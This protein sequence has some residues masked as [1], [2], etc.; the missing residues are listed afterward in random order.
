[1][2]GDREDPLQTLSLYFPISPRLALY[3]GEPGEVTDTPFEAMTARAAGYLNL[4]MANASHSQVYART[5]EP[6]IAVKENRD[7]V[8]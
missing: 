4:R 1:M 7:D 3:L 5:P 2:H 6:L 8:A